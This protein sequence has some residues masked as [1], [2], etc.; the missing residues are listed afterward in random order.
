MPAV[1]LLWASGRL[2]VSSVTAPRFSMSSSSIGDLPG[3][4]TAG[5]LRRD[6][7]GLETDLLPVR[8]CGPMLVMFRG[9]PLLGARGLL[10]GRRGRGGPGAPR[11]GRQGRRGGGR[12]RHRP[13][14]PGDVAGGIRGGAASMT[15]GKAPPGAPAGSTGVN[16]RAARRS[17]RVRLARRSGRVRAV[18]RAGGTVQAGGRAGVGEPD[19]PGE[20][21]QPGEPVAGPVRSTEPGWGRQG[22]AAARAARP[23]EA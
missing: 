14:G 16:L 6:D 23:T 21:A 15:A 12:H 5:R 13:R 20:P 10:G 9:P 18:A 2:S 1:M 8:S 17:D 4:W 7:R 22:R 11:G 3:A 19:D